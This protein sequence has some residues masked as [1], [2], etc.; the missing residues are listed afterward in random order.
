M[1]VTFLKNCDY[2]GKILKTSCVRCNSVKFDIHLLGLPWDSPSQESQSKR[3][4]FG[5]WLANQSA[6][7]TLTAV[8][9][10]WFSPFTT[11][12]DIFD[13]A[14]GFV[15]YTAVFSV[16]TQRSSCGEKKRL[17]R[18]LRAGL[19]PN[20]CEF[21]NPFLP[22]TQWA[23]KLCQISKAFPTDASAAGEVS[24]L[25]W[26]KP[27]KPRFIKTSFTLYFQDC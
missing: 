23:N 19:A 13:G 22:S 25:S 11:F 21:A 10:E 15:W 17:C 27:Q 8:L 20:K 12:G 6:R 14:N 24:W 16:V 4:I 3:A 5:G 2:T 26:V 1:N 18:R 9:L 7:K